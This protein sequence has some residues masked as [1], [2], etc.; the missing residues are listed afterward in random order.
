MRNR[1]LFSVAAVFLLCA[2]VTSVAQGG[3]P[4]LPELKLVAQLPH[5]LPQRISGLAYDG[6]KFWATIYLGRGRYVTLDPSTL[7]WGSNN[8]NEH[9]KVISSVAGAFESPGGI[10]F[11]KGQLWI[12][13]AYGGSFG[14]IDTQ[15]WKVE[16]L[17]KGK[18]REDGASQSYSS[19]AYDGNYLW[20]V[21]HWFRYELPVSQTQLLLKVDPET[22]NVVGQYP[23][24]AG[25][26]ND[27]TH[28]LTW[29]GARL[30]HMK[31]NRLSS[32]DPSTGEVTAQ[33]LLDEIKRPSGLAWANNALWI[34]EFEGKIWRL[35]FQR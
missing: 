22:G 32:I 12:T 33:Y 5:E 27:G 21:W 13:G 7:S 34:A 31:D 11:A 24:P 35:P 30:W 25:T 6:E 23:A 4:D 14:S 17:F 8:E 10:C 19:I 9:Y 29:D 1:L 16:R 18:Q 3:N 15:T 28:G 20:I 2:T 26:R